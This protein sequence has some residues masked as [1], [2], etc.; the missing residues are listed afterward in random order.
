MKFSEDLSNARNDFEEEVR[1]LDFKY[2]EDLQS[3]REE[4]A[5]K[6]RMELTE[7]DERKNKQISDLIKEHDKAFYEMKNYFNDLILNNLTLISLNFFN[8]YNKFFVT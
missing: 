5:L 7:V 3:I 8:S 6:H 2:K 1:E 4:L